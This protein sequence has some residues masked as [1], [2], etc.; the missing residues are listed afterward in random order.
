MDELKI[1]QEVGEVLKF[2]AGRKLTPEEKITVFR[3]AA[4]TV[5]V[6]MCQKAAFESLA[7][8]F[9]PIERKTIN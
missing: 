8:A 4:E 6:I 9:M 2:I 7:R 1:N 3:A 5:S